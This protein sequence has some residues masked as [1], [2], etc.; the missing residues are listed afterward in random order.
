MIPGHDPQP[1]PMTKPR[2]WLIDALIGIAIVYAMI[3]GFVYLVICA[4]GGL[5]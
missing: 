3:A 1:R 5:R 2:H 4:V